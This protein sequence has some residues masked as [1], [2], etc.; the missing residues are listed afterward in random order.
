ML[1]QVN[2]VV[3][4]SFHNVASLEDRDGARQAVLAPQTARSDQAVKQSP[5]QSEGAVASQR[6][7]DLLGSENIKATDTLAKVATQLAAL[8]GQAQKPGESQANFAN[9]LANIILNMAPEALQKVETALGFRAAGFT[10]YAFA[11]ALKNPSSAL[12]ARIVALIEAPLLDGRQQ[13]LKAAIANY[14]HMDNSHPNAPINLSNDLKALVGNGRA[15]TKGQPAGVQNAAARLAALPP[16]TGEHAAQSGAQADSEANSGANAEANAGANKQAGNPSPSA[17]RA[18]QLSASA[19]AA[20]LAANDAQDADAAHNLAQAAKD[21]SAKISQSAPQAAKPE[22]A[23]QSESAESPKPG[24]ANER[25]ALTETK[26]AQNSPTAQSSAVEASRGLQMAAREA[27]GQHAMQVVRDLVVTVSEA[28]DQ[29]VTI[30]PD[31]MALPGSAVS[32]KDVKAQKAAAEP[33]AMA[34]AQPET[35]EDVA[36]KARQTMRALEGKV[37]P[38]FASLS[39]DKTVD[40][41]DV[42]RILQ[43]ANQPGTTQART[44][45]GAEAA[46]QVLMAKMPDP[47]PF[48]QIPFPPARDEEK[49][50]G[51]HGHEDERGDGGHDDQNG[52]QEDAMQNDN[53]NDQREPDREEIAD[54]PFDAETPL[55]RNATDAERAFHMYQRFGG[56]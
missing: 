14:Q 36:Q 13:A 51:S 50:K 41:A 25:P 20:D 23:A 11:A 33:S 29:A 32:E 40:D 21:A 16:Q 17:V 47:I 8:V 52:G 15:G 34:F 44:A 35:A 31:N 42:E 10:A 46:A 27:N 30:S 9:R 37:I 55:H 39:S 7:A 4:V 1:P 28:L 3:S 12:A 18:N 48:A 19:S 38:L 54:K 24:S 53:D 2:A 56:F 49:R 22:V 5:P 43:Q 45:V 6:L 26:Q